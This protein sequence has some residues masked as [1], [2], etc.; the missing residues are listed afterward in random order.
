MTTGIAPLQ[1]G[2]VADPMP[3]FLPAVLI[4]VGL[5][6]YGTPYLDA[7]LRARLPEWRRL[8]HPACIAFVALFV[9]GAGLVT[10]AT[11]GGST[12]MYVLFLLGYARAVEAATIL[13]LFGRIDALLSFLSGSSGSDQS[14]VRRALDWLVQRLKKRLPLIVVTGLLTLVSVGLYI[15][16]IIAFPTISVWTKLAFA[17]TMSTFFLSTV[18]TAWVLRKLTNDIGPATFIGILLCVVGG[19]LYNVPSAFAVFTDQPA[20]GGPIGSLTTLTV[21]TVGWLLGLFLAL[22]F[23][24]YRIRETSPQR[25]RRAERRRNR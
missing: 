22:G 19:E 14:S 24:V 5:V 1:F 7:F 6:L 11:L 10:R 12:W 21:S 2:L 20:F 13:H 9:G 18:N 4:A 8:P 25:P 15:A 17:F 3:W 23:F 16:V